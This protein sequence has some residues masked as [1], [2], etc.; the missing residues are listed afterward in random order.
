M[1]AL[2]QIAAATWPPL[3][4]LALLFGTSSFMLVAARASSGSE[5]TV[6]VLWRVLVLILVFSSPVELLAATANV[7]GTTIR[8]GAPFLG[9]VLVGTH[10]G[11]LWL[12]R[13]PLTIAILAAAFAPLKPPARA[14][15]I[16]FLSAAILLVLALG[17]HAIDHGAIAIVVLTLHEFAAAIW[18]GTLA[19]FVLISARA[20]ETAGLAAQVSRIAL[21]AVAVLVL[22]GLYN[23]WLE[24]GLQFHLLMDS[25]YGQM[26]IRKLVT[27]A[28]ILGFAAYNRFRLVPA[29]NPDASAR[30][31][32]VRTVAIELVLIGIVF[33]WSA[34]LANS[35]PPH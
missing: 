22:T 3:L 28:A 20:E 6:A 27:F 12:W 17:S 8:A 14:I 9:S 15:S 30:L 19:S 4:A 25:L 31:V 11:R 29:V 21:L 10:I 34:L 5:R 16:L 13:T 32:L 18:V 24:L 33:G 2:Y 35:P 7:A 1:T 23:S 26:L